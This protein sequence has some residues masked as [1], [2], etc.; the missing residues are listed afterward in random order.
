[1]N[2]GSSSV[3]TATADGPPTDRVRELLDLFGVPDACAAGLLC[4][5]HPADSVAFTVVEKDLTATDLTYGEL[6]RDSARFAAALADL[7]VGPGDAVATLMGKSAD[8]V[9]ALLGIWRRGAVHVP[10]FTAFAPSAVAL[11]LGAS[12]AKAVVV[13]ADQRGKLAPSEDIPADRPWRTVVAGG[14]PEGA[15]LSFGELLSRYSGDEPQGRPVATGAEAPLILLFTSGT[16]GAPKGVPIPVKA[17][18]SFQAYLEFGLDVRDDD[19]FWNAADPGWAYGLYYAIL[20]PLA[21]GRRSLLL[22]AGFSPAL[23]WQVM[24]DFGVTNFAAAP[25]VYRSLRA[26]TD[27]VP[28]G[29]RLR[30]ASSAGEPLTPEVVGW[31]EQALGV[32]VRDHYGQTEHGMVVAAAWADGVRTPVPP[33]SM[34]RP[35]PGWSAE[36]LYEERDEPAPPGTLGRVALS[37]TDS[38]LLWF[39]GYADAPEK[40]AERFTADGRWYLTGDAGLR[41]DSGCFFFSSRDDDVI[42]MAGYRIGPFDVESVLVQHESVLEAAVIGVPDALRGEVLEAYVVLRPGTPPDEDLVTELQELVKRRFAAHAY[43]RAVHF[44]DQLPKTPSGKIQRFLLR[45]QRAQATDRPQTGPTRETN[46]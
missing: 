21:A 16:T 7:E 9:V 36:V 23:T 39:S 31:S 20:G 37:V 35:L 34:G 12:G 28:D 4:D 15:E 1:M 5:R 19:V 30:R 38:P 17:L 26:A 14:A 22:H 45:R 10:L 32:A 8:L 2:E 33:G 43:P 42:I 6:R 41:D 11:R 27:P 18:A 3:V 44:T 29:L 25:T 40:T 13:E 24:R 46:S